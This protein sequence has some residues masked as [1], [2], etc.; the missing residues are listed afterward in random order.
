[1]SDWQQRNV[2]ETA[3]SQGH[4]DDRAV[5]ALLAGAIA[6]LIGGAVWAALVAFANLEVGY[7]AWG[8]GLLV[9]VAMAMVTQTRGRGMAM[10]AAGLAAL[11]WWPVRR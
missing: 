2:N 9:G 11:A 4:G 8:I 5:P 3:W 10:L 1:M 6:A 7:V